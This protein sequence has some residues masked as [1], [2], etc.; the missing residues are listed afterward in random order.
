MWP[1]THPF[2]HVQLPAM[3]SLVLQKCEVQSLSIFKNAGLI[4]CF[5]LFSLTAL[6]AVI[7]NRVFHF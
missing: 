2:P 5:F 1:P 6:T 7:F 4:F 3:N